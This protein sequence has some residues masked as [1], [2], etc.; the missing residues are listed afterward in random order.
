MI[1]LVGIL[2]G[3]GLT[4]GTGFDG[5]CFPR[6]QKRDLGHPFSYGLT[7]CQTWATRHFEGKVKRTSP[8][9]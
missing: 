4:G 7:H 8:N 6:S 2:V 5:S 3:W 9:M 1:E